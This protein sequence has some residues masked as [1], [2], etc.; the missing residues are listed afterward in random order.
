M[1]Q[2]DDKVNLY[3]GRIDPAVWKRIEDQPGAIVD[4]AIAALAEAVDAGQTISI[5]P[6]RKVGIRKTIWL[7][8]ETVETLKRLSKRTGA[9]N[10]PLI[11]AA[12]D[13]YL[14][15]PSGEGA[16]PGHSQKASR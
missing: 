13:L 10:T 3:F 15:S 16:D 14:G 1:P 12:L 8:P 4:Q 2:M 5:P 6:S 7:T 11:L 9:Y